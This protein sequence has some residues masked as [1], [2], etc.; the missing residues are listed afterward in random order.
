MGHEGYVI[1]V[2]DITEIRMAEQER[3]QIDNKMQQAQRLE[4]LGLLAGGIAHDFNNLLTSVMGHT[5]LAMASVPHDHPVYLELSHVSTASQYASDLVKQMLAYSGHSSF[6]KNILNLNDAVRDMT[7]LL[8]VSIPKNVK[9]NTELDPSTQAIEADPVQLQQVLMNLVIN[10]GDSIGTEAGQIT[11]RTYN[12]HIGIDELSHGYMN[13][14]LSDGTY[15]VVQVIDTGCG[16][17]TETLTRIYDPFYTTKFTGRGLG[18]AAVLGIMR[19]HNGGINAVS[20]LGSGST[21]TLIF[22]SLPLQM[23]IMEKSTPDEWKPEHDLCAL[24]VDDEEGVRLVATAMLVRLGITVETACDGK[25]GVDMLAA[26]PHKY[27]LV[28]MD[29]TMPRMGGEEALDYIRQLRPD[30]PVI[31]S[32]GFTEIEMELRSDER[33]FDAFLQ[34]PYRLDQVKRV[35][36]QVM[37]GMKTI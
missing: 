25:E 34:K 29:L 35:I 23:P 4:S 9:L 11:V 10:A 28:I 36:S 2:K 17:D 14:G 24:I 32:S 6:Q 13:D 7:Q 30:I 33:R 18:M 5:S 12:R 37:P 19:S 22:P 31:I 20:C 3:R 1:V 21:F 15:A 27:G 8:T 26:N 16:M